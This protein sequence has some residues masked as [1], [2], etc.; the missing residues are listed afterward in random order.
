[1]DSPPLTFRILPRR[2][3]RDDGG[4]R[5]E[6]DIRAGERQQLVTYDFP[7]AL[8]EPETDDAVVPVGLFAAMAHRLPFVVE[9]P[10]D[11]RLA[12]DAIIAMDLA[13]EWWSEA[14]AAVPLDF[15]IRPAT[16]PVPGR[17]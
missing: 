16:T 2:Q 17:G 4:W 5:V 6:F 12:E 3:Q 10:V 1:M 11:E 8:G 14:L 15:P 13:G 7:A 9:N